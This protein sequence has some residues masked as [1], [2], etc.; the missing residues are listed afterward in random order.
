MRETVARRQEIARARVAARPLINRLERYLYQLPRFGMEP[1]LNSLPEVSEKDLMDLAGLATTV[2]GDDGPEVAQYLADAWRAI[3]ATV[4]RGGT[5]V[6]N[7]FLIDVMDPHAWPEL[8]DSARAALHRLRYEILA[9]TRPTPLS[10]DA[11]RDFPQVLL[12]TQ[13]LLN[14]PA[15]KLDGYARFEVFFDPV[16]EAIK[17]R[18]ILTDGSEHVVENR[19]STWQADVSAMSPQFYVGSLRPEFERL[20]SGQNDGDP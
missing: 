3:N 4:V 10:S 13:E 16:S 6:D 14:D 1:V 19:E 12:T 2:D 20:S 7:R 9:L 17:A 5:V 8:L 15:S 11:R 18:G